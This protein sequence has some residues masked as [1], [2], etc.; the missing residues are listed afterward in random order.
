MLNKIE[1]HRDKIKIAEEKK[2]IIVKTAS[3]NKKIEK[4]HQ[5]Y[6]SDQI[7]FDMYITALKKFE[8]EK[9]KLNAQEKVLKQNIFLKWTCMKD[10]EKKAYIDTYVKRIV[11]NTNSGIVTKIHYIYEKK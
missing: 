4:F 1:E 8:E 5:R 2:H 9:N 7:D 3:I 11:I 6:L 10:I